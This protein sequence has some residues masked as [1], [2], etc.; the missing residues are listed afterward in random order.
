MGII[1]GAHIFVNDFF[2]FDHD[3][4]GHTTGRV[5]KFFKKVSRSILGQHCKVGMLYSTIIIKINNSEIH[6]W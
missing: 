2:V 6:I 5:C 3:K 4:F 1:S